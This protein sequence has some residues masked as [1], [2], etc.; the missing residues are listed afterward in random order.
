M[1]KEREQGA[2]LDT[3]QESAHE[4][5]GNFWKGHWIATPHKAPLLQC[6]SSWLQCV[7]TKQTAQNQRA[8][9]VPTAAVTSPSTEQA[10]V[11]AVGLQRP[12]DQAVMKQPGN[13]SRCPEPA[14]ARGC[15]WMCFSCLA[16]SMAVWHKKNSSSVIPYRDCVT[17]SFSFL[18]QASDIFQGLS[19]QAPES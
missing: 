10:C 5:K 18:S 15:A 12:G 7:L 6:W 8:A 17:S 14:E 1:E 11:S 13:C 3:D 19:S 4:V 2:Q 16:D 9:H